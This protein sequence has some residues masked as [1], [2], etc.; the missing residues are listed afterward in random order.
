MGGGRL[1]GSHLALLTSHFIKPGFDVLLKT[2]LRLKVVGDDDDGAARENFPEQNRKKRLRR[3]ADACA[4]Q[5]SAILQSLRKA[6]QSGSFQ[7]VS[8]QVACRRRCRV[9]RQAKGH[10]QREA[11][12]SSRSRPRNHG[13]LVS[14]FGVETGWLE[15]FQPLATNNSRFSVIC[16]PPVAG[17]FTRSNRQLWLPRKWAVWEAHSRV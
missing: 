14:E 2:F 5:H 11:G 10:S 9:L 17:P 13:L 3:L 15:S 8:E 16:K 1:F 12:S 6:L 4:S 7:D